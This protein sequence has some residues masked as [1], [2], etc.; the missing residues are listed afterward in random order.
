LKDN[1]DLRFS[2]L[3]IRSLFLR[4]NSTLGIISQAKFKIK[5]AKSYNYIIIDHIQNDLD[6]GLDILADFKG[7]NKVLGI[8]NIT[9]IKDDQI[10]ILLKIKKK[11]YN[12][13]IELLKTTPLVYDELNDLSYFK[14]MASIYYDMNII[15]KLKIT[16]NKSEQFKLL[17]E[18]QTFAKN[19]NI[20]FCFKINAN[21]FEIIVKINDDSLES[22]EK[23]YQYINDIHKLSK[24]HLLNIFIDDKL[25][26]INKYEFMREIGVNSYYLIE[27]LKYLFDPNCILN[28]HLSIKRPDQWT[29]KPFKREN[30][31]INYSL[32]NLEL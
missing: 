16:I 21:D 20:P 8:K 7:A 10:K 4:S 32:S 25:N 14:N 17:Q 31:I 18:I 15:R 23:S 29:F 28:P 27:E 5:K 13:I 2:D 1:D 3:N 30:K 12:N 24:K 26:V 11:H 22:V 9:L 19:L 6:E